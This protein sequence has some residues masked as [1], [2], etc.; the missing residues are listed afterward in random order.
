MQRANSQKIFLQL[1]Y[2]LRGGLVA[3]VRLRARCGVNAPVWGL[4]RT[5]SS[6]KRRMSR[7]KDDVVAERLSRNCS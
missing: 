2:T 7:F 5:L 1:I 6:T 3:S 4:Y